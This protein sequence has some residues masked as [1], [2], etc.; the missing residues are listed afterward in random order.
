MSNIILPN[1]SK[2]TPHILISLVDDFF[3]LYF[4]K[5]NILRYWIFTKLKTKQGKPK[6]PLVLTICTY[7][8]PLRILLPLVEPSNNVK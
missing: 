1:Y 3:N 4:N 2:K 8:G 7:V 5:N 6:S